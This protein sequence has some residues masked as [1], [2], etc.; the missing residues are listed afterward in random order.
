MAGKPD[1][2]HRSGKKS[3]S[4]RKAAHRKARNE[5]KLRQ[6]LANAARLLT[7]RRVR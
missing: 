6:A 2:K 5:R 3:G 4:A 1:G 7:L